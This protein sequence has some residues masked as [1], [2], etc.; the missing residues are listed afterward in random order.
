ME[1][2]ENFFDKKVKIIT[3][4]K[5]TGTIKVR[6][7]FVVVDQ[8]NGNGRTY[9]RK[10]IEREIGKVNEKIAS[11]ESIFGFVGHPANAV[12]ELSEVS[13]LIE[14]LKLEQD[15][16]YGT[17]SILVDM[18]GGSTLKV[19]LKAN[20][21]IGASMRGFGEVD[22]A[23]R[24]KQNYDMRGIDFVLSPSYGQHAKFSRAD[25]IEQI[26]AERKK[27]ENSSTAAKL[28]E[29]A[30]ES[31]YSG[32][33]EDFTK[34]RNSNVHLAESTRLAREYLDDEAKIAGEK[35]GE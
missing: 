5:D 9:S 24:V 13:H 11:G 35:T 17:A 19:L 8:K 34:I 30:L 12:G 25:I 31:G 7:P 28:Y 20:A 1:L 21:K 3:E 6:F 33:F 29:E 26:E 18:K 4:D 16:G 27:H 10:L 15:T 14:N 22:S 2:R 23:G 32:T